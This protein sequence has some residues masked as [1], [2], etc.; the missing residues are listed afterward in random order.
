MLVEVVMKVVWF[1]LNFMFCRPG[2]QTARNL[3]LSGKTW[4]RMIRIPGYPWLSH[5]PCRRQTGLELAGVISRNIEPPD[6]LLQLNWYNSR[7]LI[8][9]SRDR[10]TWRLGTMSVIL[11]YHH[12]HLSP[13]F[14]CFHVRI[15]NDICSLSLSLSLCWTDE[16]WEYESADVNRYL[17]YQP[18]PAPA[19]QRCAEGW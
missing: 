10:I 5:R 14:Y 2:I 16:T 13:Y 12:R 9:E 3:A 11:W 15:H 4:H 17:Q 7:E 6:C 8:V 19:Y 18:S 1:D